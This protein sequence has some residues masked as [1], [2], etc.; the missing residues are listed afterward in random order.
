ML[1]GGVNTLSPF[2]QMKQRLSEIE[3]LS[4]GD[5]VSGDKWNL[6]LPFFK[7]LAW[8]DL[9]QRTALLSQGYKLDGNIS[10]KELFS[11]LTPI[12]S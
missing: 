1:N 3:R 8:V 10:D 4:H 7:G 5:G 9:R 11:P 2:L 6:S 12:Y